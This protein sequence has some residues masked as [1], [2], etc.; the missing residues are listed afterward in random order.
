MKTRCISKFYHGDD[1]RIDDSGVSHYE[2]K[3]NDLSNVKET[4][5]VDLLIY[6][7]TITAGVNFD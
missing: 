3:V 2:S 5:Q 6:S 1:T 7:S 4:W